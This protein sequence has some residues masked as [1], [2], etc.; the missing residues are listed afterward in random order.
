ME[1]ETY[2]DDNVVIPDWIKKMT[3]EE[4]QAE[5]ER[6]EKEARE[7]KARI[8]AAKALKQGKCNNSF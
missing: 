3:R 4:K 2:L 8:L 6:L 7:E 1:M 5:I